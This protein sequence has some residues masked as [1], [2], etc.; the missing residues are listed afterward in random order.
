VRS[1]RFIAYYRVSTARQGRSGLGLAAQ[2]AAVLGY[3]NGGSWTLVEEFT[4][5]ESGKR[6]D[7]PQLAAALAACRLHRATLVIAKLDRLARNVA[8]VSTLMES[9]IEFTAADFP[10]ANR[11]TVHILAAVAEHEAKAISD[12][13]K[14]ALAAAKARGVTLGGYR[15]R[16]GTSADLERARAVRTAAANQRAADLTGTITALRNAGVTSQGAIAEGLNARGITA[17]RG[18][19]WSAVQVRRV[20]ERLTV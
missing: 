11:L 1:Q 16:S 20:L 8:F 9:G 3:L 5:V 4:E 18:G 12:R 17:P 13:T 2:R 14:S 15:G 7:R 10:Q 6:S 19:A